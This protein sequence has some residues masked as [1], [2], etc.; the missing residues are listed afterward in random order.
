MNKEA[1]KSSSPPE[2]PAQGPK[3]VKPI[4]G[5]TIVKKKAPKTGGLTLQD[6]LT[7]AQAILPEDV[8]AKLDSGDSA[9]W[10]EFLK[11][12]R[13]AESADL[14][15]IVIAITCAPSQDSSDVLALK[16]EALKFVAT[17]TSISQ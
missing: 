2:K 15:E 17:S 12:I 3:V 9:V 8:I 11:S 10:E 7:K 16:L 14:G 1:E 6:A 13:S 4:M 5:A